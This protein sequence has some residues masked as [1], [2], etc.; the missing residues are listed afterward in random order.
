M[1]IKCLWNLPQE[2]VETLLSF[3]VTKDL[4]KDKETQQRTKEVSPFRGDYIDTK[5]VIRSFVLQLLFRYD[6][7]TMESHL[8]WILQNFIFLLANGVNA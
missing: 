7:Q 3:I 4:P 6:I 8:V 2:I 5:P 1:F